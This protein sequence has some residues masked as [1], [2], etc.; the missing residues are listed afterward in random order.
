[1]LAIYSKAFGTTIKFADA[2]G[3]PSHLYHFLTQQAAKS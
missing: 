3:R 2:K 1:M